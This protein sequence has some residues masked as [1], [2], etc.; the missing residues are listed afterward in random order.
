MN[1]AISTQNSLGFTPNPVSLYDNGD[2]LS[3]IKSNIAPVTI[4]SFQTFP[5]TATFR[6]EFA[7]F[8]SDLEFDV[9]GVDWDLESDEIGLYLTLDDKLEVKAI[10]E[11]YWKQDTE[12]TFQLESFGFRLGKKQETPVS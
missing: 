3:E 9:T 5:D 1:V 4:N 10:F 11:G 2:F 6:L 12:P 8:A 7:D